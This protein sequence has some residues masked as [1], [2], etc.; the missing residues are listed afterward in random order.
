[1]TANVI[2]RLPSRI[3]TVIQYTYLYIIMVA[4]YIFDYEMEGWT[5]YYL[6]EIS[7]IYYCDSSLKTTTL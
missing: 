2:V 6:L 7:R 5:I 1:M 4:I 3:V